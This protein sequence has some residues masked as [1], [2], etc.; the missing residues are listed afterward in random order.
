MASAASV[1]KGERSPQTTGIAWTSLNMA[2]N[3]IGA[4]FLSLPW[5]FREATMIPSIV[6]LLLMGLLNAV[7]AYALARMCELTGT[8]TYKAIGELVLGKFAGNIIQAL[9][10]C[11]ALGSCIT[12]A[13]LTGDLVPEALHDLHQTYFFFH[14]TWIIL[15]VAVCGFFP[16]SLLRDLSRLKWTS[17]LAL[18]FLF[19]TIGLLV[20][21]SITRVNPQT[22]N[23]LDASL[24]DAVPIMNVAWTF[25][26]NVP[27]YFQE[28]ENRTVPRFVKS[29]AG[30]FV[31]CAAIYLT[32]G[33]AGYMSFG[34]QTSGDVVKNFKDNYKPAL[35]ARLLLAFSVTSVFPQAFHAIRTSVV[36][37]SQPVLTP[38]SRRFGETFTHVLVTFVFVSVATAIGIAVPK[39]EVVLGYK[40][41]I[42]GS[43]IV[44]IF[45]GIMY[46]I[47]MRR[48]KE[49][50]LQRM[51]S[52]NLHKT[53]L[54]A[55]PEDEVPQLPNLLD[56][57]EGP[58]GSL[59]ESRAK[60][61]CLSH[62]C[63]EYGVTSVILFVWGIIAFWLGTLK[64]AKVI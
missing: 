9:V 12:Y 30:S 5:T 33:M 61:S 4:G 47:V 64:T 1:S 2:N 57:E 25:H 3:M 62:L 11:Y 39:V 38:I 28:L 52:V 26:Y 42:F 53:P 29:L 7:S 18:I 48:Y 40:G 41:A 58:E 60:R 22:H 6:T 32:I 19:Y 35:V 21:T 10:G 37:I 50:R 63:T 51:M 43:S 54:L 23:K 34:D 13:V 46:W 24:F 14:R 15:I 16:L 31:I 59:L 56:H 55:D 49:G 45:P 8:F 17:T 44:Y 27:R 20:S 36:L